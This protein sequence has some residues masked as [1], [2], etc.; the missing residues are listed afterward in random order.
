MKHNHPASWRILKA[1]P[2]PEASR[3]SE[4]L[5]P[6]PAEQDPYVIS[7]FAANALLRH[8]HGKN[9]VKPT[10]AKGFAEACKG[11]IER[12]G[13]LSNLTNVSLDADTTVREWLVVYEKACR[14]HGKGNMMDVKPTDATVMKDKIKVIVKK[15]LV[16]ESITVAAI[17][18]F[19]QHHGLTVDPK[20]VAERAKAVADAYEELNNAEEIPE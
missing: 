2:K 16:Y 5:L 12:V 7:T 3:S 20:L 4:Y 1:N 17:K 10:T 15:S 9:L 18:G 13:D 6:T 8:Y 11:L 14:E 19:T